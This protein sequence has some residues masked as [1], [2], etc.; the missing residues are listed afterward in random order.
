MGHCKPELLT[1]VEVNLL[2]TLA[3]ASALSDGN[4]HVVVVG[5]GTTASRVVEL[6][7]GVPSDLAPLGDPVTLLERLVIIGS[8]G[9]ELVVTGLELVRSLAE[10]DKT[11]LVGVHSGY[12][13]DS[14]SRKAE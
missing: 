2:T 10:L 3:V 6:V 8:G 7:A 11:R 9:A 1:V 13:G 4:N 14:Q 12:R 5:T